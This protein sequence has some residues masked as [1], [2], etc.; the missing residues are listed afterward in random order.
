MPPRPA[1]PRPGPQQGVSLVEALVAL[2]VMAFGMLGI[3]GI[4]ATLRFNADVARQ[5]SEAVRLAQQA[6]EDARSFVQVALPATAGVPNYASLV[7]DTQ[8]VDAGHG[9]TTNYGAVL[10]VYGSNTSYTVNRNI[11]ASGDTPGSTDPRMKAL[12]VTVSWTDRSGGLQNVVLRTTLERA[13]PELAGSVA[14]AGA[15]GADGVPTRWAR[16][17]NPNIPRPAVNFGDGTSGYIPPGRTVGDS[18]AFRFDNLTAIITLCSTAVAS[19]ELLNAPSQLSC[20]AAKAWPLAGT[21]NFA[22]A[23]TAAQAVAPTGAPQTVQ[24]G[25]TQTFPGT[26]VGAPACYT[27][28]APTDGTSSLS[29]LCAVPVS[30]SS[31][32]GLAWSGYSFVSGTRITGAAGGFSVCRYTAGPP[33]V[34]S[35]SD[36]VVPAIA[37]VQHPRAYLRVAG[38]LSAQNFLVVPYDD[39]GVADCPD[40]SPLPS[41]S[42]TYPQPASAP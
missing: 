8:V 34:A 30:A 16:A 20:T 6:I 2:A 17:R 21:V 28:P 26:G 33:A 37:N 39:G 5:R 40:G 15:V 12:Q 29:Y 35:R 10:P 9:Y 36:L 14:L 1:P 38:P 23:G 24:V 3:V 41:G 32:P 13:A 22:S 25:L 4:Q 7:N 42:T 27:A 18:T 31:L 11:V 19:N